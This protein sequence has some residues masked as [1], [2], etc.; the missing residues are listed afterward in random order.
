MTINQLYQ[1]PIC[2]F[3]SKNNIDIHYNSFHFP[4][5][6]Y[7]GIPGDL[8][9]GI[10]FPGD[11]SPGISRTEKLEGDTFLRGWKPLRA[12]DFFSAWP[13]KLGIRLDVKTGFW[14]KHWCWDSLNVQPPVVPIKAEPSNN[15]S[16]KHTER[17]NTLLR[18]S[19]G[20]SSVIGSGVTGNKLKHLKSVQLPKAGG[21][22]GNGFPIASPNRADKDKVI[23][24]NNESSHTAV[25]RNEIFDGKS[26]DRSR[27]EMFEE[28]LRETAAI[29]AGLYSIVAELESSTSKV[30]A[31]AR[32]LSR[33]YLHACKENDQERRVNYAAHVCVL[34]DMVQKT[35]FESDMLAFSGC[36]YG[37]GEKEKKELDVTD[38]DVLRT[39]PLVDVYES[40]NSVIEPK[41][42][43]DAS[44]HFEWINAMKVELEEEICVK[45]PQ[46]FQVVGQDEKV[47]RHYNS[48]Y[49][50][51]QAPRAWFAKIDSHYLNHNLRRSSTENPVQHGRSKHINFKYHVIREAEK[52]EEV[53]LKYA[54]I[55]ENSTRGYCLQSQDYRKEANS[56]RPLLSYGI[57]QQSYRSVVNNEGYFT[58]GIL[59]PYLISQK[60]SLDI[61]S[62]AT[63]APAIPV[64]FS[65]T[66]Y[67][68]WAI[69]MKTY[70]K[71]QGLWKVVKTQESI[72]AL[73]ENPTVAQMKDDELVKDYSAREI[74]VI[75][76]QKEENGYGVDFNKDSQC[77]ITDSHDCYNS[78]SLIWY[79]DSYYH[80]NYTK[81]VRDLP[82]TISEVDIPEFDIKDVTDTDVLRTRPLVDVYESCNSSHLNTPS[83]MDAPFKFMNGLMPMKVE[84]E[85]EICG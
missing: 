21:Y 56:S 1:A 59:I 14:T 35:W 43:M 55:S 5:R 52:N 78:L 7:W 60:I 75:L 57:K 65:G 18:K 8:S 63:T 83:Y 50:P 71:S 19:P 81:L 61:A 36:Y 76:E 24:I 16:S 34:L 28:E 70:L 20:R 37:G 23:G 77:V 79:N 31:P 39:R 62:S 67:H 26:D 73:G 51:K 6:Q 47:Y 17:S 64:L 9:L 54:T 84:L 74:D 40:C 68:I 45:Q 48:L 30:H 15:T 80:M 69:K 42:Y 66:H 41:S 2:V 38:T 44:K 33:F 32:C 27:I 3:L 53:K 4:Q 29:E 49:G 82:I 11:M 46:G 72:S 85:E 25:P 12:S 13:R 10:R 58:G 22:T